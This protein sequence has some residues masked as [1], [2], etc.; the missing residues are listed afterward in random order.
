[1]THQQCPPTD[2]EWFIDDNEPDFT[3]S[4][5]MG[6]I[7]CR[8]LTADDYPCREEGTDEHINDEARANAR[9]IS[10]AKDLKSFAGRIVICI[11]EDDEGKLLLRFDG[12]FICSLPA[13][14]AAAQ[15]LLRMEGERAA[16]VVK[17]TGS[18]T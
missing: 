14:S 11:V 4:T 8:V 9:L 15:G 6:T 5:T 3:V 13:N 2:G 7:I 18:A 17:A 1:M 12:H 10:A 16:A